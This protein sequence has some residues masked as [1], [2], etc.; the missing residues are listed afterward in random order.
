[1]GRSIVVTAALLAL[2]TAGAEA[3]APPRVNPPNPPGAVHLGTGELKRAGSAIVCGRIDGRWLPGSR[4]LSF[5]FVSHAQAARNAARAHR[6]AAARRF[7]RL[8]RTE[9]AA[10]APL[11]FDLRGARA[12]VVHGKARPRAGRLSNLSV[13][14][15][16]GKLRAAITSGTAN[17]SRI[18]S[19]PAG[20]VYVLFTTPTVIGGGEQ[21]GTENVCDD[22]E[23]R[24]A[25]D[26]DVGDEEETDPVDEDCEQP[27]YAPE[28]YCLLAELDPTTREPTCVDTSLSYLRQSPPRGANDP[29]QFDDAGA[30]YYLGTVGGTTALKRYLAGDARSYISDANVLLDDYLALGDG[31]VLVT[32]ATV[33]TGAR[34]VRRIGLDGKV[35]SVTSMS[36]NFLRRFADGN[37]Y[38][39]FSAGSELGVRRLLAATDALEGGWW[40]G[41][42][43]TAAHDVT[44]VC[45]GADAAATEAFCALNGS[46]I[47]ESV[48]TTD[49]RVF[50]VAGPADGGR[51]VQYY[52]DVRIPAS[53]V[54]KVSAAE[55]VG[56]DILLAGVD[57][58]EH[59]IL[60][61]H[62]TA[63]DSETVLLGP[64]D[65]FD[66]YHLTNDEPN[67]KVLFDG[68]RFSDN[69]YVLGEITM[70]TGQVTFPATS[71]TRWT[72]VEVMRR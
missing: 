48:A 20:K 47:G 34:W 15:R 45:D 35:H 23:L 4:R 1:M 50:A 64:D 36:A 42:G 31:D 38:L 22:S 16:R 71:T 33:S 72:D 60:V 32:G 43:A 59:R 55:A 10:C 58:Q 18:Y 11:R 5:W 39:G 41:K 70:A 52:P 7:R 51:L 3:K 65:E 9:R 26:E 57:A 30:V 44:T 27:V 25:G 2:L 56:D 19:A 13:L 68:L 54:R 53:A 6:P 28:I 46:R 66:V 12:L 17:V 69:R 14:T 8:A 49:G 63:D 61:L 67:G 29:V 21:T 40:I 62:K 24:Q 37:A